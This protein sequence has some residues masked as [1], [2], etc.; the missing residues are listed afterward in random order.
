MNKINKI[1][2]IKIYVVGGSNSYALF[3]TRDFEIID[4]IENS[5]LVIF[6]GGEDVTPS[7][8]DESVGKYTS[9]NQDRDMYEIEKYNE[10]INNEKICIGICRGSQFLTVMNGGKLIQHVTNHAIGGLHKINIIDE[11][12]DIE[13]TSTHHQMMFPFYINKTKYKIIAKSSTNLSGTYLNGDN[14]NMDINFIEDFVEPEIVYY[15]S[16]NCLCI[17]GHPEIM[18]KNSQAVRFINVLIDELLESRCLND[19]KEIKKDN[20]PKIAEKQQ[21]KLVFDKEYD[22]I[23]KKIVIN[24]GFDPGFDPG[25]QNEMAAN[26]DAYFFLDEPVA[27]RPKIKRPDFQ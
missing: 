16:T 5:D 7:M 15:N 13:I 11:N 27:P 14:R 3:I 21:N 12:R 9:S 1:D 18:D 20:Q 8:Y 6:T 23:W 17:Q 25:L 4:T 24:D 10:A 2:K 22:E 19:K 26:N